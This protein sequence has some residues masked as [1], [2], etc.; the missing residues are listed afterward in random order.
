MWCGFFLQ[1]LV[2]LGLPESITQQNLAG[3]PQPASTSHGLPLPSAHQELQV[4][5]PRAL[6]ARSVPPS[7]FGYPLDGFL[8]ASPCRFCFAPAALM[9]FTLR[10]VLLPEGI[11]LISGAEEPTYRFLRRYT[12]T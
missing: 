6:P 8:P 11:R 10:S 5:F 9:G 3:Q 12:R 1:P 2:E 4:H 7:G